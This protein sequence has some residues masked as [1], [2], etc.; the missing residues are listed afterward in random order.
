MLNRAP[1][2]GAAVAAGITGRYLG[3]RQ[4]SAERAEQALVH[5][6]KKLAEGGAPL[7]LWRLAELGFVDEPLTTDFAVRWLSGS[8]VLT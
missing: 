2:S 5:G 1:E 3:Q 7:P 6:L 8:E 4:A